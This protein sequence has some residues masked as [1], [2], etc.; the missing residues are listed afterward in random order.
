MTFFY[1]MAFVQK[2]MQNHVPSKI[3][4]RK[5]RIGRSSESFQIE[6]IRIYSLSPKTE[7]NVQ[8]A[9]SFIRRSL[10]STKVFIQFIHDEE[11][12]EKRE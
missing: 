12:S 3:F 7:I 10:Q 8:G 4:K 2:T 11:M 6:S 9:A 1:N 5:S